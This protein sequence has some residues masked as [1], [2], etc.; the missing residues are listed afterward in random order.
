MPTP[1]DRATVQCNAISH[2]PLSNHL[3]TVHH[4]RPAVVHCDRR[5]HP[6]WVASMLMLAVLAV[7]VVLVV[8]V[9]ALVL[10][11]VLALALALELELELALGLA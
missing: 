6:S 4:D 9:L 10:V 1:I 7:L 5:C 2:L 3:A 8:L 11:L